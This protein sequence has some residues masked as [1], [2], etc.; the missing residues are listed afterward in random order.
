MKKK[1]RLPMI[2]T[3]A[4]VLGLAGCNN[5]TMDYIIENEPSMTGI[6]EEVQANSIIIYADTT[7]GYP[8]GGR[9]TVSLDVENKD[10]YTDVSVGDE[11]IVYYNGDIAE[12]DPGQINTVYGI[13]LKTPADQLL[14]AGTTGSVL[15]EPPALNIVSG[16]TS[17]SALRGAYW[18]QKTNDDGTETA[19]IAD[20]AHPL[21]CEDLLPPFETTGTTAT[22]EFAVEPSAVS[23][24]RC[25]SDEHWGDTSADNEDV[26]VSGNTFTLKPGGYIYEITAEWD[27]ENGSGGSASYLIYIKTAE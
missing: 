21:D 4:C 24:V 27:T 26:V 25:W 7:E 3:A 11:V 10:S 9:F 14:N 8:T 23:S 1:M 20:S 16:E 17:V 18:W 13:I 22:L 6:V 5:R 15:E 2:L 12:T 19:T